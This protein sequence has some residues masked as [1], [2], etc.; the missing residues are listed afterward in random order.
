MGLLR[1]KA[2]KNKS[3]AKNCSGSKCASKTTEKNCSSR[4]KNCSGSKCSNTKTEKN[5]AKKR[6][7]NSASR[8]TKAC[9]K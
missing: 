7:T 1:K 6:T 8:K 4:T 9:A 5:S 3:S 2:E